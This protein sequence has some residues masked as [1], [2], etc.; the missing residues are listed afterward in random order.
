MTRLEVC[1]RSRCSCYHKSAGFSKLGETEGNCV[2]VDGHGFLCI[3]K[4]Q[5]ADFKP[6]E[7]C[8]YKLELGMAEERP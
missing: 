3:Q 4:I 7:S 2:Y 8:A 6:P 1:Q 5:A